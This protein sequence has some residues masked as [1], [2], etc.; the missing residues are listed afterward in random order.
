[1]NGCWYAAREIVASERTFKPEKKKVMEE[2]TG[3]LAKQRP[4]CSLFTSF[5]LAIFTSND[6]FELP[7]SMKLM[8]MVIAARITFFVRSSILYA[9][10]VISVKFLFAIS[11]PSQSEK[12]RE[13][14]I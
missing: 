4:P 9:S 1:M 7:V 5:S 10:I 8:N 2:R 11:T 3:G 12:S 14:R 13:Y 6:K